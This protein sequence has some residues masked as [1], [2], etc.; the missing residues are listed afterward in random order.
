MWSCKMCGPRSWWRGGARMRT[1]KIVITC[2]SSWDLPTWFHLLSPQYCFISLRC[3]L[4][5]FILRRDRCKNTS[6]VAYLKILLPP[7]LS[8]HFLNFNFWTFSNFPKQNANQ[9]ILKSWWK[10]FLCGKLNLSKMKNSKASIST[11]FCRLLIKKPPT[12]WYIS[13]HH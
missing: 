13:Y 11:K 12:F 3:I 7:I 2:Y 9:K 1:K 6:G 10:Q 8:Q 4:K 5:S